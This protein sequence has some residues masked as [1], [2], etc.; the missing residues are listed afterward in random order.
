MKILQIR[1]K[2]LNSLIGVW[3]I[4]LTDPAFVSDGIFAITGP[5]GAGKTTILDAI[6]LALYGRTPR[7][8]KV[9]KSG[10][11][12]M[13][14]RTGE[15]FAEVTFETQSGRYRCHWSQRRANK[16]PDGN[17]QA[18]KH[19]IADADSGEIFESKIRGVAEQIEN[20]TGMDFD[21]FTQS[22]LLAQGGFAAFLQA[23]PDDRAPILEQI[24]G[25]DIYSQISIRVH[26]RCS[27]ERKK[28]DT[29]QAELDGMTLLPKED[30]QQLATSLDQKVKQEAD[31]AQMVTQK[32]Q[33]IQWIE[34]IEKLENE[35][36]E[37]LQV[38]DELQTRTVAFAPE[39]KRLEL[40]N[41]ALELSAD[42]ASL[43][44]T[45]KEQEVDQSSLG[46]CQKA[47]PGCAVIAKQAEEAMKAASEQL[48]ARKAEQQD[49]L[50]SIRKVRELDL[51]ID[52]RNPP[53]EA[54]RNSIS[55]F[56]SSLEALQ[57]KQKGDSVDLASQRQTLDEIQSLLT[58]SQ[59]DEKLVEQLAGLRSRFDSLKLLCGQL[60]D[61]HAEIEKADIQFEEI[62][63]DWQERTTCLENEKR[64]LEESKEVL[65]A[66]QSKL[67]E[68]L[69][70][71]DAA[72]W[73]KCQSELNVKKDL[74]DKAVAAVELLAKSQ[75]AN[76][77][78]DTRQIELKQNET[79]LTGT[80]ATQTEKQQALEK[81]V[82][83]LETQLTLIKRIESFEEARSHL[84]AGEPCPLCGA[85]EH[86]FAEDTI[87][88]PDETQQRLGV[89]RCEQKTASEDISDLKVKL[90][91]VAKDLEQT[92]S[93]KRENA[94]K[95]TEAYRIID[96]NCAALDSNPKLISSD[97][98][99]SEK[100]KRLQD[101]HSSQIAHAASILEAVDTFEKELVSL[102]D[103]LEK[104]NE[105]VVKNERDVQN[106]L[107]K[108]ESAEQLLERLRKE[109]EEYQK[110]QEQSLTTLQNEVDKFGIASISID[111]I[112]T[113]YKQLAARRDQWVSRNE[114]KTDLEQKIAALKIQE[115][116]QTEQILKIEGDIEKQQAL[117]AR[118]LR[119]QEAIK[120]ERGEL[121]GDKKAEDEEKRLSDAI[122]SADKALEEARQKSTKA[123]QELSQLKAKIGELEKATHV[124]DLQL[125]SAKEA[126]QGRLKTSGFADEKNY[127][128]SCLPE[129]ER[130][131]LAQS[132]QKLSDEKIEIVAKEQGKTK[133]LEEER[134]KEITS[135]PLDELKNEL[136]ELTSN[137]KSIQQEIGGIRQKLKDNEELKSKH[138]E[139]AQDI[140]GQKKE[141]TR[142]GLLDDLIGHSQGK[143]YRNFAQG[144]TFEMMI[145]HANRQLRKM[146]DRYLLVRDKD[147]PLELNVIDNYQAGEIRSTKN[148]S[149]GESFIVS[150]SL[151][152]GLSQMASKNVRVD[153]L[154][155]DEGFGTLDEEALETAL[156][157]LS[158]LQQ[159]G[160]L[161]GVISHVPALKERIPA[162]ISIQK[163][164]GGKSTV[165]GPGCNPTAAD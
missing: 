98:E 101:E 142:W 68:T 81:E 93:D 29:L 45:R 87:P 7:L 62:L 9:T 134:K 130:K 157:T 22:M 121:F 149:G 136:S 165:T 63:K 36:K 20:A 13:S 72:A 66:K 119:E 140:E 133:L 155:L 24:T 8:N 120:N 124:R 55:E 34:G 107:H 67:S 106:A 31:L 146:N 125:K 90:A 129:N 161:I 141:C 61:K 14:R 114:Q 5:T 118:L 86:P 100:L 154:F 56:S 28:L 94:E 164:S 95:I 91:Q 3:T 102:R 109:A 38:K 32:N 78:F 42:Y 156:D 145:G 75:Q 1:F 73:R 15:C 46:E 21:R 48:A 159:E 17:L 65:A 39:Q 57:T 88:V 35:L 162:Q 89:V 69:D 128:S 47:L 10:N 83:L 6:C 41:Q 37:I 152:L 76:G 43:T 151:A 16:K 123:N 12:I 138:S 137:Q 25:T 23:A 117:L 2:N 144:L 150:L 126:F 110:Q 104:A 163:V 113:V 74:I 153:S 60:A 52:E 58:T 139:C 50:P 160:K 54:A 44:T 127:K 135:V 11:E 27:D 111:V 30:E 79:M 77:Q 26:E 33:A 97:P 70:G 147:Q 158:G 80:L 92:G 85:K 4:D 18:P 53:I 116:H 132:S 103:I 82:G 131:Q 49:A 59:V 64:G 105:S 71:K 148:L 115:R 122:E 51:K 19:E 84:Q 143:T 99:L 108:K 96:D 40:A 112:D